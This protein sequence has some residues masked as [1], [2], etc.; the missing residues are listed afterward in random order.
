MAAT[1]C[2]YR[3]V[4]PASCFTLVTAGSDLEVGV[5]DALDGVE[6]DGALLEALRDELLDRPHLED[7][8][9]IHDREAI[10]EELGL[11]HVVRRQQHRA[12]PSA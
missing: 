11:L 6:L 8:A 5:G 12:D 1:S 7:A 10:A 3:S 9:V 2:V 4:S